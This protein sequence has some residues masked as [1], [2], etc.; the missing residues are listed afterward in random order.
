M[1][2][3]RISHP[4]GQCPSVGKSGVPQNPGPAI[5]T[6][7]R[8]NAVVPWCLLTLVTLSLVSTPIPALAQPKAK[9]TGKKDV[10]KS[11][12]KAPDELDINSEKLP[13]GYKPPAERLPIMDLEKPLASKDELEKLRKDSVGKWFKVKNDCDLSTAGR[14]VVTDCIKYYLY[15][16]TL[17]DVPGRP[18]RE[19]PIPQV[20]QL[21][22]LH[23]RFVDD[24]QNIGGNPA[25]R[26]ADKA[27]FA[28]FLGKEIVKQ[29]P[30]LLTN[31]FY[32][33]LHAVMILGEID[34]AGGYELL[35]QVL[36][37]KDIRVDPVSGQPDA[38][39]IAAANSLIR[40]LRFARPSAEVNVRTK[41]AHAIIDLLKQKDAYWWLQIRLIEGLRY[42]DISGADAADGKPFVV[43]ALLDIMK[44]EKR[45][46][47]VRMKACYA[48]GRVP[49][50]GIRPEVVVA[51]IA[52]CAS[53][54]AKDAAANPKLMDWKSC[55]WDLYLTFV[56]KDS[57][58]L[59]AEGKG[60]G[61]LLTRAKVVARPVYDLIVPLVI[62][63]LHNKA[64]DPA[65]RQ[66]LD[67]FAK[68]PQTD[69]GNG[70]GV[71]TQKQNQNTQD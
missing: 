4:S 50:P 18:A 67:A 56:P 3:N 35:L 38:V 21:P 30:E 55:F 69:A 52:E 20:T 13:P 22:V 63:V 49:L 7:A 48:L 32:V 6:S 9:A 17:K 31:N 14:K 58:D 8:C 68:K 54:L 1:P 29:I 64:P 60:P 33:R 39:K 59:D 57:K 65:N 70:K 42:C 26:P 46:W 16:M 23:K 51:E 36:N 47:T 11:P 27:A 10:P 15:S 41:I 45:P 53:E 44:D 62:D 2:M 25:V 71:V 24:V 12:Q 43:Q 28:D 19:A 61:G 34:F 40:I 66:K 37:A 5:F